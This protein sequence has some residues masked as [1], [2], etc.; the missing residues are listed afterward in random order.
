MIKFWRGQ[1]KK[2]FLGVLMVGLVLVGVFEVGQTKQVYAKTYGQIF[3]QMFSLK[4]DFFGSVG[5]FHRKYTAGYD[6]DEDINDSY[7][8]FPPSLEINNQEKTAPFLLS[9]AAQLLQWVISD[10]LYRGVFFSPGARAGIMVGWTTVRDFVNMFYLLILIFLAITTI[11]RVNKFS[12]KKLFFNVIVSAILVNFSLPITLAVIDFS[13][14][15]MDFFAGAIHTGSSQDLATFY[16]NKA[17]YADLFTGTS[18]LKFLTSGV[19]E[20]IIE[21]VMAIMLF[22]VAISLLVRLIAYWVLIIL[23][24]L[25][26]FTIAMPNSNSFNEWKDKLINYSFYGPMMLFFLWLSIVLMDALHDSLRS[27]NSDTGFVGFFVPYIVVMYLLYYGHD[28]SKEMAAKAGDTVNMLMGKAKDY[29]FG[30]GKYLAMGGPV[31]TFAKSYGK[32]AYTGGKTLLQR[33]KWTE[34]FTEEGRKKQ[35]EKRDR[36][37]KYMASSKAQREAMDFQQ[38]NTTI[39]DWKKDGQDVDNEDFLVDKLRTGTKEERRAAA[40]Q[41]AQ[42][43]KLGIDSTGKNRYTEAKNIARGNK[44]LDK[45]IERGAGA[46]NKVAVYQHHLDHYDPKDENN[47]STKYIKKKVQKAIVRYNDEN[48][49]NYTADTVADMDVFINKMASDEGISMDAA[50]KRATAFGIFEE[51][52]TT[53]DIANMLN[54]QD[55]ATGREVIKEF[56]DYAKDKNFGEKRFTPKNI[57]IM[58]AQVNGTVNKVLRDEG[59]FV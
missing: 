9:K 51:T 52:K 7:T 10:D 59:I 5:D 58:R 15:L 44:F 3:G 18:V 17:G 11:L 42:M 36:K 19:I 38:A 39:D 37:L 43:G 40:I 45:A 35:Q 2:R 47:E 32:A 55:N 31:G 8:G 48:N 33:S 46:K 6:P 16:L 21:T 23:S 4:G 26:F 27:N 30:A 56:A 57:E 14:I 41:L 53:G 28:K 24:P 50:R 22:F 12:D 29:G 13:N 1:F 49:T 25:A 20:F 54:E 34:G